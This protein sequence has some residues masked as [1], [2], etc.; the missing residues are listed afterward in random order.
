MTTA[1][2]IAARQQVIPRDIRALDIAPEIHKSK[3]SDQ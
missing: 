2:Q 3:F 1:N